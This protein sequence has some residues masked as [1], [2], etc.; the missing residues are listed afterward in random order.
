MRFCTW[1]LLVLLL[2]VAVP[3]GAQANRVPEQYRSMGSEALNNLA[4]EHHFA[5][6][7]ETSLE[8]FRFVALLAP[9]EAMGYFNVACALSLMGQTDAGAAALYRAYRVDS[10]WTVRYLGDSDLNN[11]RHEEGYSRMIQEIAGVDTAVE[12]SWR[13]LGYGSSTSDA[14]RLPAWLKLEDL[15]SVPHIIE[16]APDGS[17]SVQYFT[18]YSMSGSWWM[19]GDILFWEAQRMADVPDPPAAQAASVLGVARAYRVDP[20]VLYVWPVAGNAFLSG[21]FLAAD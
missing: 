16:F 7:Y 11:I 1:S 21:Y 14:A 3:V 9:D 12:G 2:V 17:F 10:D 6:D 4:L 18:N 13:G 15:E 20:N 19:D 5:G 8:L